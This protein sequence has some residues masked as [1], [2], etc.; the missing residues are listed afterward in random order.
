MTSLEIGYLL[1]KRYISV[2]KE[3]YE[4]YE[5]IDYVIGINF[6][7]SENKDIC[8][9]ISGKNNGIYAS[10]FSKSSKHQ[11][12]IFI[13]DDL[14]KA[15]INNNSE[16]DFISI[17]K[18]KLE[19][20]EKYYMCNTENTKLLT[21][22]N[23]KILPYLKEDTN[24]NYTKDNEINQISISKMYREIKKTI[25]SQDEQITKILTTLFKNQKV[26]NSNLSIDLINKLKENILIYGPTGTGKTEI[27]KRISKIY[28]IPLV[29]EDSTSLSETGYQ[30]RKITDMLEDL[31]LKS[32]KDI[33]LAEK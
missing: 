28:N 2:D 10:I 29:I 1:K 26:I 33:S 9:I 3:E 32:N 6:I 25:F 30:G 21:L 11:D 20:T 18:Q 24:S 23:K 5:L 17:R 15:I 8:N 22:S 12:Y 16:A 14:R 7:N 27:L 13:K 19:N 31:Y 4:I